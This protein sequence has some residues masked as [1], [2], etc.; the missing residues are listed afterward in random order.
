M[1]VFAPTIMDSEVSRAVYGDYLPKALKEGKFR[2]MPKASVIGKGL[3]SLQGG[4][5]TL[6][7]GVSATKLVVSLP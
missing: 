5:D 2:P 1:I 3:E 7:Q 6:R 4:F